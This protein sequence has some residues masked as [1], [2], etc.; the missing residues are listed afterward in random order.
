MGKLLLVT[1]SLF[2]LAPGASALRA[3]SGRNRSVPTADR[4]GDPANSGKP[5]ATKDAG[6][7]RQR[8]NGTL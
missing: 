3:Q 5:S 4:Q 7:P 6:A 2:M 1:L 8:L